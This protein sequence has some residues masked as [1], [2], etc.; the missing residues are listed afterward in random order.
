VAWG[1]TKECKHLRVK[2]RRLARVHG[3]A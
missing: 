1:A 3:H 2:R